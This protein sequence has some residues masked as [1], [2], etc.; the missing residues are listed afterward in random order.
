MVPSPSMNLNVSTPL[1]MVPTPSPRG[2]GQ[3]ELACQ[4][5]IEDLKR[6]TDMIQRMI[7]KI[8][9]EGWYCAFTSDFWFISTLFVIVNRCGK[10]KQDEEVT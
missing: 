7:I 9:N 1:P 10:V 5:K 8:G 4:K 3:E 6:Y 2:I